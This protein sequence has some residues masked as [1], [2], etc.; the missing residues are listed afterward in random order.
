MLKHT[1]YVLFEIPNF[2][3]LA[4]DALRGMLLVETTCLLGKDVLNVFFFTTLILLV[5]DRK[6]SWLKHLHFCC[7][8]LKSPESQL[9]WF[10]EH[11]LCRKAPLLLCQTFSETIVVILRALLGD[12][13]CKRLMQTILPTV[14]HESFS[15]IYVQYYKW[16]LG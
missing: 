5:Q 1:N 4:P 7:L 9:R 3:G 13:I 6:S 8:M 14:E 2:D 10:L 16:N 12:D 15:C 11:G